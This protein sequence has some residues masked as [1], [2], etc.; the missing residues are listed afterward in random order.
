MRNACDVITDE[1]PCGLFRRM[2]GK[3]EYDRDCFDDFIE[4]LMRRLWKEFLSN[5]DE[6]AYEVM[7]CEKDRWIKSLMV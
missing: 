1:I 7:C 6:L 3:Y 2:F 4:T 5:V